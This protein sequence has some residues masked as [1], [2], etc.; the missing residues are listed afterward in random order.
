MNNTATTRHSP[1][2]HIKPNKVRLLAVDSDQNF[3]SQI[4]D[5]LQTEGY[6]V[7]TAASLMEAREVFKPDRFALVLLD[8]VLTN[9]E[10]IDLL[11]EIIQSAPE[12]P[13]VII[14]E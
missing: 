3:L 6:Q 13:V 10:G 1:S 8:L 9:G 4:Q 11:R 5:E 7:I 12:Q 14:S 2:F